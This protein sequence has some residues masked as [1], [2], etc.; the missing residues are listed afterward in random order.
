MKAGGEWVWSRRDGRHP[1]KLEMFIAWWVAHIAWCR[2]TMVPSIV[3][4]TRQPL[5]EFL[6]YIKLLSRAFD[7][8]VGFTLLSS[9]PGT[10]PLT[11]YTT[12]ITDLVRQVLAIKLLFIAFGRQ[13][14]NRRHRSV[15]GTSGY[16]NDV[17]HPVISIVFNTMGSH[18]WI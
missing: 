17:G 6:T 14:S 10:P 9:V 15:V 12:L 4:G 8:W 16:Y 5:A 7:D 13:K 3:R 11:W 1:P 18:Y 2:S